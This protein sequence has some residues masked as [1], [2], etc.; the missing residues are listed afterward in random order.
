MSNKIKEMREKAGRLAKRMGEM[1]DKLHAESRA[2]WSADEAVEWGRINEEYDA[3]SK[4]IEIEERVMAVL[5]PAGSDIKIPGRDDVDHGQRRTKTQPAGEERGKLLVRAMSGWLKD[6]HGKEASREERQAAKQL[7]TSVRA[8]EF[9]IP[10]CASGYNGIRSQF[11]EGNVRSDREQRAMSVLKMQ[12]G[13]GLVPEGFMRDFE[14]ALLAFGGM[15]DASDI[16][17]TAEGN[18]IPWPTTNDTGNKATLISEN[19]TVSETDVTVGQVTFNAYKFTSNIVN[20]PVELMEDSAFDLAAT[21]SELLGIRMARGLNDYYTTGTGA[22]QPKG[23]VTAATA[24][25]AA[26]ANAIAADDIIK[27]Y[28]SVDPLYRPG[29]AFMMNDAIIQNIRTLKNGFGDYIWRSGLELG[30]P[31][32][33]IGAP[34]YV[35]QSMDSTVSS[36]KKTILYGQLKKFKIREVATMRLRRLVERYADQDQEAFVAFMRADSNLL[37][38]GTH[39]VKVLTH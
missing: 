19:A 2:D 15:R 14:V 39:P 17:R 1:R 9:G 34:L 8:R 16:F 20:V 27:L 25:N 35:N 21:L 37:D 33:L 22:A 11:A 32:T 30:R 4:L 38:A 24:F 3:N 13:G 7:G 29:G 5:N 23:I 12:S 18:P 6:V 10:L 31:D 26:S 36:G 28:H